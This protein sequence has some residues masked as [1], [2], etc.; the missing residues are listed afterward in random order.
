MVVA[1]RADG[2]GITDATTTVEAADG[3][4]AEVGGSIVSDSRVLSI[5]FSA[6]ATTLRLLVCC[7]D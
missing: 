4:T 3:A 7:V 2:P 5:G 6:F 1:S